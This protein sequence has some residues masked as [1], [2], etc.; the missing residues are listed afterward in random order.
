M[1]VTKRM[2]DRRIEKR[3]KIKPF[4]KFVNFNHLLPTRYLVDKDIDLKTAA[5]VE[6]MENAES[7]K[8]M[9]K[10]VAKVLNSK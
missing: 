1:K 5:T 2:S 6:K 7:R 8:T 4:V 3:S 9:V 10:E